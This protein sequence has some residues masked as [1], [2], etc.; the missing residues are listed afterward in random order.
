MTMLPRP[1]LSGQRPC[2]NIW[3]IQTSFRCASQ[4]DRHPVDRNCLG[5]V[6]LHKQ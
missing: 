1:Q 2:T 4:G 6:G 5:Y 3:T